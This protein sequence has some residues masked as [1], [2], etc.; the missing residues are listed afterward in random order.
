MKKLTQTRFATSLTDAVEERDNCFATVIAC[1]MDL[2][3]PEDAYQVQE[4]YPEDGN[5]QDA[6][7]VLVLSRWLEERGWDWGSMEGHLYDSD[8]YMV[9]GTSSRGTMHVCIYKNGE[10]WHDPHPDQD[11]LL[12]EELYEYFRVKPILN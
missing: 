2:D 4:L 9:A 5:Q 1:F 10:L 12:A 8:Y 6:R 3:S 11:G 7:W